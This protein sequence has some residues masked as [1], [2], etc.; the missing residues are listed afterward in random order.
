MTECS[1]EP[2]GQLGSDPS[3]SGATCL[4]SLFTKDS[5][6]RSASHIL[7]TLESVVKAKLSGLGSKMS[8]CFILIIGETCLGIT[9]PRENKQSAPSNRLVALPF[10][11]KCCLNRLPQSNRK[12]PHFWNAR[13]LTLRHTGDQHMDERS[14]QTAG[15]AGYAR[16]VGPAV[17]QLGAVQLH[18]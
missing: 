4:T 13:R 17:L 12:Y 11:N 3:K 16:A 18:W 6:S 5:K 2:D 14:N 1:H 15:A 9:A 10:C 7:I 8:G